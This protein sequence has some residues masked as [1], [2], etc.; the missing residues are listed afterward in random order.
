AALR[1]PRPPGGT[2]PVTWV[3]VWVCARGGG[4]KTIPEPLEQSGVFPPLLVQIVSVG[5]RSGRLPQLL[6][7]AADAMESRTEAS[8]K[9]FTTVLPPLLVVTLALVV[10]FVVASILLPLLSM[11]DYIK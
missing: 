1:P 7:Q 5:E 9:V 2:G 4:G 3:V 6:D 8:I 11:Q 10:G